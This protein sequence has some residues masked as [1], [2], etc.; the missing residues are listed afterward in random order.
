MTK[1]PLL[2]LAI[3]AVAALLAAAPAHA[4]GAPPTIPA[5][6]LCSANSSPAH[7]ATAPAAL[8]ALLNLNCGVC[9]DFLCHGKRTGQACGAGPDFQGFRCLNDSPVCQYDGLQTCSCELA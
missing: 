4:A 1:L 8:P 2:A 7:A 6:F 9:S 3:L 5:P